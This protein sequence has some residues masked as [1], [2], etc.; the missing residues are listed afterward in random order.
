[1]NG[2]HEQA[3]IGLTTEKAKELQQQDQRIEDNDKEIQ[4]LKS[5]QNKVAVEKLEELL[6]KL[7]KLEYQ[8]VSTFKTI[9]S[10]IEKLKGESDE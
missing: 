6:A 1:M 9:Y 10:M 2:L 4:Q 5:E 8:Q 7:R 3:K